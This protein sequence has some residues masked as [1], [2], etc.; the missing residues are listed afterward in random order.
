MGLQHPPRWL[1]FTGGSAIIKTVFWEDSSNI[2]N[3]LK[4]DNRDVV[5]GSL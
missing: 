1:F 4:G 5:V 2:I 3:K